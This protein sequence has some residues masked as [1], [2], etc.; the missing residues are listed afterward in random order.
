MLNYK[1]SQ[2]TT[3]IIYYI[4]SNATGY[5]TAHNMPCRVYLPHQLKSD[6]SPLRLNL[7]I[8]IYNYTSTSIPKIICYKI[9][10]IKY[11]TKVNY[12]STQL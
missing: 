6:M 8:N 9:F 11:L 1:T 10:I 7:G 4:K 2:K 12:S 5:L 3:S